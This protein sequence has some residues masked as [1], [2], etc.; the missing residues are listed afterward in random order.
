MF[1]FMANHTLKT[2]SEFV[3]P[4]PDFL[5]QKWS[6]SFRIGCACA[7]PGQDHLERKAGA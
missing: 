3:P 5:M 4:N 7:I 2:V 6:V 1:I